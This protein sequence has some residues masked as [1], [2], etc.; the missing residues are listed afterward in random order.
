MDEARSKYVIAHHH[1]WNWQ[2]WNTLPG[3]GAEHGVVQLVEELCLRFGLIDDNTQIV[4]RSVFTL[5]KVL[6]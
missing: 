2:S 5:R 3:V 1:R 6:N 4:F